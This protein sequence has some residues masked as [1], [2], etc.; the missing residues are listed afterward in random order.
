MAIVTILAFITILAIII[1]L[2]VQTIIAFSRSFWTQT[3]YQ[4][5]G[6]RFRIAKS[7]SH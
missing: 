3:E 4:I 1:I 7:S 5:Q 2:A 6:S